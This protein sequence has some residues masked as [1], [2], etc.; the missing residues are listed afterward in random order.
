SRISFILSQFG[1]T[2]YRDV[3]PIHKRHTVSLSTLADSRPI[4]SRD[5]LVS[6]FQ[7]GCKDPDQVLIGTEHEKFGWCPKTFQRP[8]YEPKGIKAT[9]EGF[10][11]FGWTPIHEGDVLVGLKRDRA[12]ITLEP[13][14]Q[15]ELSGAPVRLVSETAREFDDHIK[16][17]SALDV[18]L[19][20]SGLGYFPAGTAERAPLMPK[21]RYK[22]LEAYLR[23]V[24][25]AG[26]D[27]MR[28][29]CTVQVNLDYLNEVDAMRK[30]RL[31]LLVHPMVIALFANSRMV[32]GEWGAY[33]SQ[34]AVVWET[35]AP[36]RTRL[37]DTFYRAGA[38]F[39]DYVEWSLSAPMLFIHRN[40]AYVD[41]RGLSFKDF[42]RDGFNGSAATVGDYALHLSTLFPDVRL[43]HY[44]EIRGAD[45]GGR[46][47]VLALPALFKGLFYGPASLDSLD[48]L[49]TH[50]TPAASRQAA[51]SAARDG[52][53]GRLLDR[54][55]RDWA[56]EVIQ[57]AKSGL[58]ALEPSA[59]K[60]LDGLWNN[61]E[62]RNH[63]DATAGFNADQLLLDSDLLSL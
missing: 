56:A 1:S 31:G 11:Q 62:R 13:G 53:E 26:L 23:S 25:G 30:L 19:G 44:L 60:Y 22:I 36:E 9:L 58:K 54:P 43:K 46:T 50:V 39:E 57:I 52:L 49:F 28:Q 40:D 12:T 61:A 37:P 27:M 63:R 24:G 21:P 14:G 15:L 45:M 7:A 6:Y 20:W 33:A 42:I 4:E 17:L 38:R 32:E 29:T 18:D 3:G 51:L 2:Q 47:D 34:R 5:T 48:R 41:C 16:E 59:L 35:T 55:L 10:V 8:A